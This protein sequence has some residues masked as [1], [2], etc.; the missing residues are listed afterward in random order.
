MVA[1]GMTLCAQKGYDS[2][3]MYVFLDILSIPQKNLRHRSDAIETLG[4]FASLFR[5]FV[6][7]APTAVHKDTGLTCDKASYAR[8]GWCRLEQWG[9]MCS[10]GIAEMYFYNGVQRQLEALGQSSS[11]D[12]WFLDSIMVLGGDYTRPDLKDELVDTILGL[13]AMVVN[14]LVHPEY[15]N[16]STLKL[17]GLIEEHFGEVFPTTSFKGMPKLLKAI[18]TGDLPQAKAN[19]PLNFGSQGMSRKVAP[20]PAQQALQDTSGNT[21][22]IKDD[23]APHFCPSKKKRATRR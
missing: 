14:G 21:Y 17:N 15:S 12:D 5:H 16:Q 11:D 2:S 20:S 22:Q 10:S 23:L 4:V 1:A 13:Y 6:I 3:S 7:I 9:H 18:I 8:R 19:L